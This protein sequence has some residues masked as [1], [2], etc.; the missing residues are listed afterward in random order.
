MVDMD[1][2][3]PPKV[4]RSQLSSGRVESCSLLGAEAAL[5]THSHQEPV[6]VMGAAEWKRQK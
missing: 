2:G 5:V 6:T 4:A 1:G 3:T